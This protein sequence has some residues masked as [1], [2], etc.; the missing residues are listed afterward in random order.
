MKELNRIIR[1]TERMKGH[2]ET[3]LI[4]RGD[5]RSSDK[6][7]ELILDYLE[8]REKLGRHLNMLNEERELLREAWDKQLRKEVDLDRCER[9]SIYDNMLRDANNNEEMK[10]WDSLEE[11]MLK[12]ANDKAFF[13]DDVNAAFLSALKNK[14]VQQ[15]KAEVVRAKDRHRSRYPEKYTTYD[16]SKYI[17]E[18][19]LGEKL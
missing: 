14:E 3:K 11:D 17:N 19:P 15:L 8:R 1:V 7:A 12:I 2:Y 6:S 18:V 5:S 16:T 13:R 10:D 9:W 4:K